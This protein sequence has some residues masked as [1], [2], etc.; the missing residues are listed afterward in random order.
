MKLFKS[1]FGQQKSAS[2]SLPP[3]SSADFKKLITKYFV[4]KLREQ[5]WK[6]SGYHFRKFTDN[7]YIYIL[8]FQPD[9][10]GGEC[11]VEVGVHLDFLRNVGGEEYDLKKINC[12]WLDIRRRISPD[13]SDSYTWKYQDTEDK[14]RK[15]LEDIWETFTTDGKDFFN[16]F[17]NFPCPFQDIEI[18]DIDNRDEN[19]QIKGLPLPPDVRTA[20]YLSQVFDYVGDKDKASRFADF[21]LSRIQGQQGSALRSDLEKIKN[22]NDS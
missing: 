7:H 12:T 9:K 15:V 1:I 5:G 3:I 2:I 22:K 14:N 8:S 11:W 6:G 21:G 13:N 20:W 16:Q 18:S 4:P 17:K 19:Y 10:Y